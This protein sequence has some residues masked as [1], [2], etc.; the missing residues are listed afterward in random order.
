MS[1]DAFADGIATL[2][3]SDTTLQAALVTLLGTGVTRVIRGNQ[4]WNTIPTDLWPTWIIE[5]GE[6]S[7]GSLLNDSSDV[8]GLT[9]GHSRAGFNS[10][11]DIALLWT[12]ADRESANKQ[13]AKLPTLMAQLML[14]N[15]AAGGVSL[16]RLESWQ[17]DQGVNHPRQ[18]W[19]ATLRAEYPIYR[20]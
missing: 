10:E 13:R 2:L 20:T 5:Q 11:L 3:G 1:A 16:A 18:I 6:G 7:A 17:P 14:R 19:L 9:I 12:N 15:P 8:D 4:P